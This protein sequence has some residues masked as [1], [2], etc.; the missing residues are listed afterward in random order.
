MIRPAFQ[1]HKSAPVPA[2]RNIRTEPMSSGFSAYL[3]LIS[4]SFFLY[5]QKGLPVINAAKTLKWNE[6]L[7]FRG[8]VISY[9]EHR[10]VIELRGVS[11]KRIDVI[12]H[13]LQDI[14]QFPVR[15]PVQ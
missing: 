10:K 6:R 1:P 8:A 11:H 2:A 13:I 3:F 4:V 5:E 9:T 12:P 7:L 15:I 14:L